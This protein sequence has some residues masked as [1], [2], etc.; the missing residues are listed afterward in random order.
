MAYQTT[1]PSSGAFAVSGEGG[2]I[3]EDIFLARYIDYSAGSVVDRV[4]VSVD[5][6]LVN[7]IHSRNSYKSYCSDR[8]LALPSGSSHRPDLCFDTADNQD[9]HHAIFEGRSVGAPNAP[10]LWRPRISIGG[11]KAAD[12][13]MAGKSTCAPIKSAFCNSSRA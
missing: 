10:P 12:H 2:W 3:V 9:L 1:P 4:A 7:A 13:R 11:R 8:H 5:R 6:R